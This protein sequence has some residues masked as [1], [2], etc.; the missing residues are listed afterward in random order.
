MDLLNL[1]IFVVAAQELSIT[2]TATRLQRAQSN[3]STRIQQLEHQLAATLFFRDSRQLRLTPQGQT[4]LRY[5]QQLLA[6]SR[7]AKQALHPADPQGVLR[8]GSMESTAASRLPLVL[9][10]YQQ[11]WPEVEL[12]V[13]T[14]PSAELIQH[15][16]DYELDCAFIALQQPELPAMLAGVPVFSEELI[17]ILPQRY[18]NWRQSEDLPI[19]RLACFRQGCTYR[20]YLERYFSDQQPLILQEV[21][22]YHAVLACVAAG[23]CISV[24]P[25]SVLQ[26]QQASPAIVAIPLGSIATYLIWRE[27]QHSSAVL[28]LQHA[29]TNTQHVLTVAP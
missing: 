26:L 3:I 4:F 24:L 10:T 29:L 6:L 21:G 9:A 22:S 25:R 17:L 15:V 5:S 28:Q 8:I 18:S 13:K 20:A 23:T 12:H 27:N 14:G 16:L 2:R 7:E 11:R 19:K 1:E